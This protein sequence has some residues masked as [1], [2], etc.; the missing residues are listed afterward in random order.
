MSQLPH[1]SFGV[2]TIISGC[3]RN[4]PCN[5][6][7]LTLLFCSLFQHYEPTPKGTQLKTLRTTDS[8]SFLSVDRYT[9][10]HSTG[11]FVSVCSSFFLSK[12]LSTVDDLVGNARLAQYYW[13]SNWTSSHT[14]LFLTK[15]ETISTEEW[16]REERKDTSILE[17]FSRTQWRGIVKMIMT[18]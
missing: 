6:V 9:T 14:S 5:M 7:F 8:V 11:M 3:W 2:F 12:I 13:S 10:P 15:P 17:R 18:I 1:P 4:L 16:K